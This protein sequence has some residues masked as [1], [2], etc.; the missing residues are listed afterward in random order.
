MASSYA[1]FLPALAS[2]G[3]VKAENMSRQYYNFR[4]FARGIK[5]EIQA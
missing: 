4:L 3:R 1:Y 5:A 2:G